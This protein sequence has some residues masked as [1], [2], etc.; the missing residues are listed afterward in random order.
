MSALDIILC[1]NKEWNWKQDKLKL[2][3]R[4]HTLTTRFIQLIFQSR[5]QKCFKILRYAWTKH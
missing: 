1:G 3:F 2:N 5:R 4:R